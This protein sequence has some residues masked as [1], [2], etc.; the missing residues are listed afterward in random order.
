MPGRLTLYLKLELKIINGNYKIRT[1]ILMF[2]V[3][4]N[5]RTEVVLPHKDIQ[6]MNM[7][8][9]IVK[10]LRK[11]IEGRCLKLYGFLIQILPMKGF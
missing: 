7:T 5:L 2:Y 4:H 3:A 8:S 10:S 6:E 1:I 11:M 9:Y